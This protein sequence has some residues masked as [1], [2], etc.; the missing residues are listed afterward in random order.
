MKK[1]RKPKPD[2]LLLNVTGCLRCGGNHKALKFKLFKRPS[3]TEFKRWAMCPVAKEP[4]MQAMVSKSD[5]R[6]S[7]LR[8]ASCMIEEAPQAYVAT[9][10]V[11]QGQGKT[12][13]G[14][15]AVLRRVKGK[16]A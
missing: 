11:A 3:P 13:S 5:A 8:E 9:I 1:N 10:Y 6:L 12:T 14:I 16:K 2:P 4:L 15:K 7:Q